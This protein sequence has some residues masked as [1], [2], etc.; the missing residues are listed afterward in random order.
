M[1]FV[2][3][4]LLVF[5]VASIKAQTSNKYTEPYAGFHRAEDLFEKEQYSAARTEFRTFLNEYKGS[6]NDPYVQKALYYEGLSAL[7]LFNNDAIDLL[8][9]FM[10]EYPESIYKSN[11][12]LHIGRYY[13]Q[14]KD[15]PKAIEWL[16]K[17]KKHDLEAQDVDEYYFKLG[18]ANFHEKNYRDSKSA[19]FEVKESTSQ[20]GPPSL[21]Y[22]SHICYIDSSYQAALEGFQRL[23][24]DDRFKLVVPY[25]IT[26]I[27]HMQGRYEDIVAFAPT[28]MDSLKP[29]EKVEMNHIIGNAYYRLGKYDEAVSYL[30]FYN[31][32]ANTTRDD[33]YQLAIAY[34]KSSDCAKAVK[35]F[36]KVARIKDTLGQIALYH[37]GECYMTLNQLDFAKNAF[38][39]AARM[40]MDAVIE[41]D[42]LFN[43]AILSYKLDLNPYDETV[44]AFEDY[45]NTYP[46]STRK[47]VIYQYLVNVYTKTKNY[48][49]AL[50]SLD[51]LPSKDSKLKTA[52][53]VI[54]FNRG[55][56]QYLNG[57]YDKAIASFELVSKYPISEEMNAKAM[58]WIG[59]CHYK[60]SEF[61]Q[62][63]SRY[64]AFLAMPATYTTGL[65]NDAN[66]NKGYAY[67]AKSGL[68]KSI[69]VPDYTKAKECFQAYVAATNGT[70]VRKKADAHMRLGDIYYATA[71]AEDAG[72]SDRMA[73]ANYQAAFNLK[74]G[75]EDQALYYMSRSYGFLQKQDEKIKSLL[76]IINNYPNSRY[77]Q[78]A[79]VEVAQ[80]Y[81]NANNLDK[82][83]R[84][85]KQIISDYPSSAYVKE[86]YHYLGEIAFKRGQYEL[87]ETNYRKV[88]TGFTNS[89]EVCKREVE[90]LA[91]V[92]RKQG[93]ISKIENLSKEFACA[94]SLS[95]QVED[96][97]YR[98][99]YDLY[100]DSSFAKA[101]TEFDFYLNKYPNG[102]YRRDALNYKAEILYDQGKEAEA[103]A[104]Y[105]ETLD[106]PDDD[107][108]EY[109]SMRS[110]KYLFN[111]KQY[112]EALPYYE[113]LEKVAT[114]PDFKNNAAIGQ[115]R[116]HFLLENFVNAAEY[117]K[118]V[119]ATQQSADLKLEAEYI[120]GISLAKS[121]RFAEA[122]PSLEY[123]VKN[124]TKSTGA[125]AKYTIAEG[126]FKQKD[127]VKTDAVIRELQK[128]KPKYD[129]WIAKGLILQTQVLIAQDNLFQAEK[130]IKSVIDYYPIQ[131]DGI[132]AEA[133]EWY[134]QIMILKS[135]PKS[136][137]A[138]DDGTVIDLEDKSGEQ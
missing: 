8:E 76:D 84:Y 50:E 99:A 98:K 38:E 28:S 46:N 127:Y 115:M 32:K 61:G 24:A 116:C 109:A 51:R 36:D 106:G 12:S 82:A 18:Y 134:D 68:L 94:D 96:E 66:Y 103:V 101:L 53:Q 128:M 121:D 138:P 16:E 59:D 22:Y 102:K 21:Y 69:S 56:E 4:F 107:F 6:K 34:S 88:L 35:Y 91:D 27:Y 17:L 43:F 72:S 62:A 52:Y 64:D 105:R 89:D 48:Q 60:K 9:S 112:T 95:N 15:Y 19:F 130:T 47:N 1:R 75:F 29:A 104:I 74:V 129:Y 13:Y 49:K 137:Q 123:V 54:A 77:L 40:K 100:E 126:Y 136:I 26:Q 57:E 133:K 7:E 87:A 119:L 122:L 90:S 78:T 71:K 85:M 30:E 114:R 73:I 25:Y 67:L 14:K 65:R 108:T 92:Y 10:R 5:C 83:E 33:D 31:Q 120:K 42:A 132:I 131:D 118:K 2:V 70:D 79:V 135:K 125:E 63:I 39:S 11:I 23:L 113:R 58:F 81:F 44:E 93:T 111:N 117:A 37:A 41:E 86:A 3:S 45:L 80:A 110:A 20:Y 55:V 124:T 97:Y